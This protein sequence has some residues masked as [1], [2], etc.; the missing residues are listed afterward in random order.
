MATIRSLSLS[1]TAKTEKFQK[2]L[3]AARLSLYKFVNKIPGANLLLNKFSLALGGA[4]AVIGSTIWVKNTL[5]AVDATAK[6]ADR[7]GMTVEGLQ[8][9]Q[10]AATLTGVG[11]SSLQMG[12]QRMTR[13]VAEAARGT[14]EAK[15]A[16]KE[17]RLSA[18]DLAQMRPEEMFRK[19]AGAMSKVPAQ[20]DKVRLAMKLFDSEGVAMVNTLKMGEEGLD[21]LN[22]QL[23]KTGLLFSRADAGRIEEANDAIASLKLTVQAVANIAVSLLAPAITRVTS[24]LRGW[25]EG[26]GNFRERVFEALQDIASFVGGLVDALRKVAID[27]RGALGGLRSAV[28]AMTFNKDEA[29]A[30]QLMQIDAQVARMNFKPFAEQWPAFIGSLK[31]TTES[32]DSVLRRMRTSYDQ[33]TGMLTRPSGG[34]GGMDVSNYERLRSEVREIFRNN[35]QDDPVEREKVDLLRAIVRNGMAPAH[36]R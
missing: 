31:D 1:V 20:G 18:R 2:G 10:H 36:A 5:A 16:L 24:A 25:V 8:T 3:K 29:R 17:L 22:K 27:V 4:A 32:L 23:A 6:F 21:Q 26:K 15:A 7:I 19:I 12:L 28:G 33:Q 34:L 11:V 9:L 14:G 30:G 13:R 35:K